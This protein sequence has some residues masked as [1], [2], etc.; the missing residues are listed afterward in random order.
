[1]TDHEIAALACLD[2]FMSAW[3]AW[4]LA[5]SAATFNYPSVRLASGGVRLIEGAGG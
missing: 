1:M 5:R 3:N 4:D 2:D